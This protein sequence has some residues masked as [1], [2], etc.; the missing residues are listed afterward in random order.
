MPHKD[1][2]QQKEAVLVRL[3]EKPKNLV[4]HSLRF[5]KSIT[6]HDY[7]FSRLEKLILS[8]QQLTHEDVLGAYDFLMVKSGY[9]LQIN[10][11]SKPT[12]DKKQFEESREFYNF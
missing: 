9:S 4:E 10:T 2:L 11:G 1:F 3:R 7:D 8:V 6:M 5:W 12:F